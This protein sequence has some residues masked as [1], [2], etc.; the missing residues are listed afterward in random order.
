M[1]VAPPEAPPTAVASCP[2]GD[3][4]GTLTGATTALAQELAAARE[5]AGALCQRGRSQAAAADRARAVWRDNERQAAVCLA[6]FRESARR[7]PPVSARRLRGS[8]PSALTHFVAC[9]SAWQGG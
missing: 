2:V 7:R 6:T 8:D 4:A 5:E 3:D 9:L 1:S